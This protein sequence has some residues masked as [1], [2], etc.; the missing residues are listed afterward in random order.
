MFEAKI[1]APMASHVAS[2]PLR[3]YSEELL[4]F[5]RVVSR[6]IQ[7]IAATKTAMTIQSDKTS[8]VI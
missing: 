6:I 2:L 7:I 3:K 5:L 1:D 8:D 4:F